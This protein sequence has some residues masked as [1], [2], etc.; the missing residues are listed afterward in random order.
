MVLQRSDVQARVNLI[1]YADLA[2]QGQLAGYPIIGQDVG[3]A[4]VYPVLQAGNAVRWMQGDSQGRLKVSG[5]GGTTGL[6]DASGNPISTSTSPLIETSGAP[7][8]GNLITPRTTDTTFVSANFNAPAFQ[9]GLFIFRVTAVT[10]GP[11]GVQ[12]FIR[13]LTSQGDPVSI[14]NSTNMAAFPAS[15]FFAISPSASGSS[16]GDMLT[17][18]YNIAISITGGA[19]P[20]ATFYVDFWYK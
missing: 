1:P 6:V 19:A 13:C 16:I 10:G 7:Q 3:L 9:M 15:S 14:G 11:T 4:L 17:P 18:T 5:S 12:F 20:T 2:A 8:G